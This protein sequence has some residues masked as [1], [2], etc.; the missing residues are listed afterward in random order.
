MGRQAAARLRPF[1]PPL[2][3]LGLCIL[4]YGLW[5]PRM[6]WYWD[7]LPI[8]WIARTFG[9]D[10][11]ERYFSTVR[12]VWG[13]LYRLTT[14]LLGTNVLAWQVFAILWR[15]I[16]GLALWWLL[17]LVWPKRADFAVWASALFLLYPGFSQQFISL[18][19]SHFFIVLSAFLA[20]LALSVQA[21]RSAKRRWLLGGLAWVLGLFNLLCMEYFFFLELVRPLLF[22]I[23]FSQETALAR[24]PV[25]PDEAGLP[26]GRNVVEIHRRPLLESAARKA[27]FLNLA[28]A[29]RAWLPYAA[30]LVGVIVWRTFFFQSALYQPVFTAR[31]KADPSGALLHLA[32]RI[33]NDAWLTS[34]PRLAQCLPPAPGRGAHP[35]PDAH[36][37]GGGRRRH[38]LLSSAM[39][40]SSR[41]TA[42][43]EA[44]ANRRWFPGALLVG[45]FS[46]LVGGAPYW[47]TDLPLRL[48]FH[49][50]RFNL[51]FMFGAV[52]AAVGL[53]FLAPLPR[54][55][56]VIPLAVALGFCAGYQYQQAI[57]YVRDWNVQQR[58]FWQLSWRMP[59]VRPGT[60]FLSNELPM[61]HYSDNSLT[62]AFNWVFA[63]E[64]RT[65][66]LSYV[67]FYPT[68]RLGEAL[69]ALEKG[70]PIQLDYLAAEFQGSTSSTVAFYYHPPACARI[71]DPLVER[72]NYTLPRYLREAMVLSTTDPILPEG[73]PVLPE[74][75]FGSQSAAAA[76]VIILR[77]PTWLAS[78]KT[79]SR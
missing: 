31:L 73:T 17:R 40:F 34:R 8:G 43:E 21:L 75:I 74:E 69:P 77:K 3:L 11:L 37:L 4:A 56:R 30:G 44:P 51:S 49:F 39:P 33:V 9:S 67:L 12:P 50:D 27:P 55:L 54:W 53:L 28:R 68:I 62:A 22:W 29:L 78:R 13:L 20:S 26:T 65:T 72:D 47:L 70:L 32:G 38:S 57:V 63:P 66:D 58:L 24:Q 6:G 18:V 5:V 48:T 35:Q 7:D 46:L 2:F 15:W 71:L 64:N 19:Y 16:S 42:S 36:L 45:L 79:G 61:R 23:V 14:P 10:G 76:G 1:L 52:L 41:K 25:E 60:V 59:G